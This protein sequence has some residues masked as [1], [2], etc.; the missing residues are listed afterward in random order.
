MLQNDVT[1]LIMHVVVKRMS[2]VVTLF[3]LKYFKVTSLSL[4]IPCL[5][6]GTDNTILEMANV[7]QI[8]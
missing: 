3:G 8:Q 6:N 4:E 1:G 2:F 5:E 7:R